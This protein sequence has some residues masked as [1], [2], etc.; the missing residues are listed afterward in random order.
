M[1]FPPPP[2]NAAMF[3]G[4][5]DSRSV[6][7]NLSVCSGTIEKK[8]HPKP[9]SKRKKCIKPVAENQSLVLL[10]E[11][12]ESGTTNGECVEAA[13]DNNSTS[14][15]KTSKHYSRRIKCTTDL[16]GNQN[17]MLSSAKPTS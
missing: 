2:M 11:S 9:C 13:I 1:R 7:N 3:Q 16:G 10:P 8:K 15:K 5:S 4:R 17:A 14:N 6:N 12:L